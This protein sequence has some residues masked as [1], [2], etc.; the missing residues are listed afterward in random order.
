MITHEKL[1]VG[2]SETHA[3]KIQMIRK[4]G[5]NLVEPEADEDGVGLEALLHHTPILGLA[6]VLEH[7]LTHDSISES[8][9]TCV[10]SFGTL[11]VPL[12]LRIFHSPPLL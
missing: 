2:G 7:V 3:A 4:K 1:D 6:L 10:G 9:P 12:E 11:S 8:K 5:L